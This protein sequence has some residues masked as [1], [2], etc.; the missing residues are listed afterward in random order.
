MTCNI[1]LK[2]V[3]YIDDYI[4]IDNTEWKVS[5]YGVISGPYLVTFLAV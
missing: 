1:G 5:K 2:W 3:K 4:L